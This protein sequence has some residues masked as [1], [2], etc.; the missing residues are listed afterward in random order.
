MNLRRVTAAA[1]CAVIIPAIQAQAQ[2]AS[3]VPNPPPQP[4]SS[5]AMPAAPAMPVPDSVVNQARDQAE[6]MFGPL[7]RPRTSGQIQEV[8]DASLAQDSVYET[9]MCG[10]C[11][12]KIRTREHMVTLVELPRGE[13]IEAVDLG[14]KSGFSVRTRGERRLVVQP[15]GHGYDTSLVVYG[16]SGAV[17]SF[18]MRAEGF[19]SENIPDLLVRIQGSVLIDKDPAVAGIMVN[20]RGNVGEADPAP[21]LPPMPVS[22]SGSVEK[23]IAGLKETNPGTPEGDFVAEAK[24]DP[25]AL[26]GWGQYKLWGSD[27]SLR[28]ET[29]FRDDYVTYIR[30]GEKWKD[31]ELPTAYVVVDGI[32]EVVN[33]RVEGQT[34]IIESTRPLITLKSGNSYLCIEYEGAR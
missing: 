16:K 33:T 22:F 34:Y 14:D 29:V 25:N 3:S 20:D 31:I 12:Y 32:D 11:T 13:V 27:N 9:D 23:A 24:F 21:E 6:G 15:V 30:F 28:P 10:S 2:T 26:R 19:N 7:A 5:Q 8:W 1:L 17:Y 4:P 18:Y